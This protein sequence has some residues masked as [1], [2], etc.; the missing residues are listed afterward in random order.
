MELG[1]VTFQATIAIA[2]RQWLA[3]GRRGRFIYK[4]SKLTAAK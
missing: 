3:P 2:Q 1:A 4:A